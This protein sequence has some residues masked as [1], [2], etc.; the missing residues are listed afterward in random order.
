MLLEKLLA[1]N[2]V[3][4]RLCKTFHFINLSSVLIV[5]VYVINF[6]YEYIGPGNLMQGICAVKAVLFDKVSKRAV[7]DECIIK[8]QNSST[9]CQVLAVCLYVVLFLKIWSFWHMMEN[10]R[11]TNKSKKAKNI[12]EAMASQGK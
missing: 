4:W 5:P 2:W 8:E 11:A 3:S 10:I 7:P 1:K 12:N 6:K 9:L